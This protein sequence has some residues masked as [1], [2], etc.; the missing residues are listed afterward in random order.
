M[1]HYKDEKPL[2]LLTKTECARLNLH[3]SEEE[4]SVALY[5]SSFKK[6]KEYELYD[7]SGLVEHLPVY[8]TR[9]DCPLGYLTK[10]SA[11]NYN[12]SVKRSEK[13]VAIVADRFG[14]GIVGLYDKTSSRLFA[15][16]KKEIEMFHDVMKKE[17]LSFYFKPTIPDKWLPT[18]RM[19]LY[20]LDPAKKPSGVYISKKDRYWYLYDMSDELAK[21]HYT[22]FKDIPYGFFSA[23]HLDYFGISLGPDDI[24][25]AYLGYHGK[26]VIPLYNK[27][28]HPLFR[29]RHLMHEKNTSF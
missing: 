14:K 17:N 11:K 19:S 4:S 24:P 25:D 23:N 8:E 26:R 16:F 22:F 6:G 2:H 12:I 5:T 15:P 13:P 29:I 10:T 1:N 28:H 27:Q 18:C 20:Y 3:V 9:H 7:R 21:P